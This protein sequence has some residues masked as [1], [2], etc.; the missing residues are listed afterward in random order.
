MRVECDSM[1]LVMRAF[2]SCACLF[3]PF[4]Y[5]RVPATLFIERLMIMPVSRV[6]SFL[7]CSVVFSFVYLGQGAISVCAQSVPPAAELSSP[8][9]MIGEEDPFME[10]AGAEKKSDVIDNEAFFDAEDM[11]PR[12]E[13]ARHGP[14]K[15]DPNRQPASKL[16][17]VRKNHEAD[18]KEAHLVAA[19]RAMKLGRNDSSLDLFDTLY[20]KNKKD[21]RVLM[22]RAVVL[23]KL[24]RFDEA[25]AMYEELAKVVPDNIEVKVNML[26]LLS[27]R[28]PSIAL[29]RLLELRKENTSHVGLA[30]QIAVCYA[31]LG[32]AQEALR[33][34][35][36][37]ASMEPHN[38]N[39]L[40]NMAIV[41]DRAG[42]KKQ[43][44]SYYEKAL[45][46]D[47]VHGGGRTIPRE[48]VYERLAQIR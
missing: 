30:S 1:S 43:A 46:V 17:I 33:Y 40:Y 27:T 38:A 11:L 34:M 14:N 2:D 13:M 25:M 12:G 15:V 24:G 3:L 36:A 23:Q 4:L 48:T 26:G 16:V 45:E 44:V 21:P 42:D 32:D 28:F 8:Q 9:D 41:A 31:A 39:H 37:A 7:L 19:E 22:G 10:D 47:S 20:A 29:R 35:G 5:L 6:F 18:T